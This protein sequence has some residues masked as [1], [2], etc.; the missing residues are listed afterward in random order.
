MATQVDYYTKSEL[1]L[2]HKARLVHRRRMA[3]VAC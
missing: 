3:E 1:E 2:A